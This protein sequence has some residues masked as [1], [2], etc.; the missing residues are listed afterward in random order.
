M[1]LFPL[2]YFI[3][4]ILIVV[5]ILFGF[6][7]NQWFYNVLATL[8]LMLFFYGLYLVRILIGL[9]QFFKPIISNGTLSNYSNTFYVEP[10]LRIAGMVFLPLLF[11][12]PSIRK[13]ILFTI[14][15]CFYTIWNFTPNY[16]NV[17]EL[18]LKLFF[19]ISVF[20][21][22]YAVLWFFRKLPSQKVNL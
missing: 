8:N 18:I 4:Q 14:V 16:W 10:I 7:K 17:I 5:I 20:A 9:V 6:F 12:I 15:I 22:T 13:N 21:S 11:L 3:I 2:L 1:D 19:C